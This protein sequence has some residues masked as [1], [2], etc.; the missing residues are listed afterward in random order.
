M[1][2]SLLPGRVPGDLDG[3]TV[4]GVV[5]GWTSARW[6]DRSVTKDSHVGTVW[7]AAV[8]GSLVLLIACRILFGISC[9]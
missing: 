1:A 7:V 3:T 2:K 4:T 6:L 9:G 5:G 8:G